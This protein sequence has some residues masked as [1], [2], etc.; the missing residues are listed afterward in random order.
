MPGMPTYTLINPHDPY[1]FDA[2]DDD[3]AETVVA[4]LGGSYGWQLDEGDQGRSGGMFNLAGPEGQ[5][6]AT[7]AIN[8]AMT[9]KPEL[10]AALRTVAILEKD[11]AELD[12]DPDTWHAQR[13]TS[14]VDLR[15]IARARADS[16]EIAA[17]AE[18]GVI[19]IPPPEPGSR[20]RPIM[21]G[22]LVSACRAAH[23]DVPVQITLNGPD[24][25]AVTV[26]ASGVMGAANQV[27][28]DVTLAGQVDDD[29][30]RAFTTPPG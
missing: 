4:L 10:A 28:I 18:E 23:D 24:D 13:I 19:P 30:A 16:V 14:T 8:R 15:E 1:T 29:R 26:L 11:R 20:R 21:A 22:D 25:Q 5:Q 6:A 17:S 12:V 2:P 3:V 7:D 9:R 27:V